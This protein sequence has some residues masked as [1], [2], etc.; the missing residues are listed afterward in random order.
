MDNLNA[1]SEKVAAAIMTQ[2][3][4]NGAALTLS[5]IEQTSRTLLQEI[6]RRATIQIVE[7]AETTY[8]EPVQ[9][10]KGHPMTYQRR[11]SARLHTVHGPCAV[12][13]RYYL[14]EE[15]HKGKSPLDE[16]LG[17]RPNQPSRELERL[18]ALTGVLLPYGK[19]SD[20]FKTLMLLDVSE[21]SLSK[22]AQQMG[23]KVIDQETV[24]HTRANDTAYLRQTKRKAQRPLRLYGSID[25]AKV[26]IREADGHQWRDLKLA[27]WFTAR[28]KPPTK[29]DG[30]WQIQAEHIHYYAD[31]AQA[32]LFGQLLWSS[33]VD[34]L[35]HLA[36]ELIFLADGANW[37]W[38]L[39]TEH[40][41]KAIQILD[42]F[43]A[44]E[45]LMPVAQAAFAT[46]A[47][48]TDCVSAM[49]QLMWQGKID[50]L[51]G[52]CHQLACESTAKII[53]ITAN[54][55]ENHRERMR[56]DYFRSQ[57]YQIGSGTIESAAKQ[58]GLMRMK[59]PGASWNL[60]NARKVA[61]ARS[62]YLSDS[63]QSLPLAH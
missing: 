12:K 39:V 60:E 45:H 18:M 32:K 21:P 13:R 37:I 19:A 48:Q 50:Q 42:W 5:Q 20:L 49:K 44:S 57:G 36:K 6:G 10:E 53:E 40:F 1:I 14:C 23:Q 30:Q 35:A 7:S 24:S 46:A 47:E 63:W 9:C 28:G 25:A 51:I 16:R 3:T 59:V 58:I 62:A 22:A 4:A 34:H 41:P 11:R 54:Y 43:H 29:P 52:H 33:G 38:N 61:K 31:I 55:F 8:P 56:Y 27:A 17:L 2:L 15:C 26:Q